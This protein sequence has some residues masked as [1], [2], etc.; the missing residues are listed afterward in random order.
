MKNSILI[1][2][3]HMEQELRVAV[4]KNNL[5]T[6]LDIESVAN[7]QTK[8]YIYKG[9]VT[10][11]EPS[12]EACFIDYGETRHGFLP[13]KDISPA[14]F[15]KTVDKDERPSIKEVIKEGQ[16]MIVQ[17]EK[18]ERGNKGAA[19]TTYITLAGSYLVLMPNTPKAGGVSRRVDGSD[20]SELT[21]I[22][23]ALNKPDNMGVIIRTASVGKSLEELQWDLDILVHL[24]QSISHIAKEKSAP[25][26]IHQESN[27]MIRALRDHLRQETDEIIIDHPAVF[28]EAKQY[29]QLIR[30]DFVNHVSLYTDAQ[31]LFSHFKVEHQVES[32]FKR[33]LHLPSGGSL[34]IDQ[35]EALIAIDI[36]S[37]KATRGGDIEE[38]ALNTNLEAA[39][40]IAR[41]LRLRDIGGLIV[42]D[43]IDMSQSKNQRAVEDRLKDLLRM[44]RA[45]VQISRISRFG[46]L[47]MSRQRLRSTLVEST[48]NICRHCHGQGFIRAIP[49]FSLS[50]LRAIEENALLSGTTQIRAHLPID[51]ATYLANEKRQ[52]I[53]EIEQKLA[54]KIFIIAQ[55][56]LNIPDYEIERIKTQHKHETPSYSISMNYQKNNQSN[57]TPAF[58]TNEGSKSHKPALKTITLPN[59]RRPDSKR[60]VRKSGLI[61]KLLRIL[62]GSSEEKSSKP[63]HT[64][65]HHANRNRRYNNQGRSQHASGSNKGNNYRNRR[66]NHTRRPNPR[67]EQ[68]NN[69]S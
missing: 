21:E 45:K 47:E 51:V 67:N 4:T 42:I 66:R 59:K 65:R 8:A 29:I 28:E 50:V 58:V 24:W 22:L 62:T 52:A 2:A 30:P 23:S 56:H 39:D 11:I 20:R 5:L 44:D 63:N 46:L 55:R 15:S 16:E 13:L 48:K 17:V 61:H 33:E 9:K 68:T 25:L 38:T 60:K 26:L 32:V 49:S 34:A 10:R 3:T 6:H 53:T 57:E 41:Q 7:Q 54:I 14:Y 31:P 37:A 35:T 64:R 43:F 1:N 40:E 27:A 18:I 12:L 36:N 69:P 19:L